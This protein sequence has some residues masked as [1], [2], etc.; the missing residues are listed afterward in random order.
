[1]AKSAGNT[2]PANTGGGGGGGGSSPFNA[3]NAAAALGPI[4]A[5]VGSCKR[6][7]GPTGSGHA[8]ITFA[9]SGNVTSVEIDGGPFPG[10]SVGGC[11]AGKFRGA[12][13]PAFSGGPTTVGKSFSVN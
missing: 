1:M 5:G 8:K 6:A 3:G 11:V 2:A 10:T 9:P 7:D 13:V 12:H 4:A